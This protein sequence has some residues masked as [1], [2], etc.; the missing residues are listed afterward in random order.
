MSISNLIPALNNAIKAKKTSAVYKAS[1]TCLNF[2]EVL[3][4]NN[5]INGFSLISKKEVKIYF[6][7]SLK[8]SAIL[9]FKSISKP[10]F[11]IY[12]SSQDLWKFD[13]S[14]AII[15]LSTSKGLITHKKALSLG[16]GG[17]VLAYII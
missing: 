3:K 9:N 1:Y 4:E 14:L 6:T 11:P 17:K 7:Y 5:F 15:I 13:K 2:L 12:I 10:S 8:G 16:I